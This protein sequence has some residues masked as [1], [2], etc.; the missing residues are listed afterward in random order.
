M[1]V[2]FVGVG[3]MGLPMC[4]NLVRAGY[5]VTAAD[6]RQE[7]AGAVAACGARWCGTAAGAA[8]QADVLITMLPG[9]PELN[10]LM[11][12]P[13]GLLGALPRSVTWIDMTSASPPAGKALARAARARGV[14]KLEAPVGGGVGAA[15]AG[16]L[17]LFAAGEAGVLERHRALLEALADPRRIM[18]LGKAGAGYTAKL[19]VNLLWFGQ[20]IATAEALLLARREGIDVDVLR[21]ALADSAAATSFIRHDLEA[22]LS[23]DYLATF[24]LDRVCEELAAITGLARSRSVPFELS[25][26]VART[27]RRALARYGPAEGELL[28][29]AMLEEQAGTLLR[30]RA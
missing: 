27:Y 30:H 10:D 26:H 13:G 21:D 16:S 1:G 18:Y 23:G 12:G 20:A 2:A 9:T 15:I 3:R 17:Q 5:D 8:R 6:R 28:A 25:E 11:L 29:V 14:A 4:A 22:L 24:G 19:L 7:L